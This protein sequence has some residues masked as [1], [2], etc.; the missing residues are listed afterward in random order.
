MNLE[1]LS[2]DV[3]VRTLAKPVIERLDNSRFQGHRPVVF[4]S[5]GYWAVTKV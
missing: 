1:S 2:Q 3:V 4:T 5:H